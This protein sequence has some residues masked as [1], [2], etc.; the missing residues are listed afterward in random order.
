VLVQQGDVGGC[1]LLLIDGQPVHLAP[2][3]MS[4]AQ[5]AVSYWLNVFGGEA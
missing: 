2:L 1:G 4:S 3:G 5:S